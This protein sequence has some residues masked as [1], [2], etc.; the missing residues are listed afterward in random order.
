MR[1][2]S[3]ADRGRAFGFVVFTC[4]VLLFV[5]TDRAAADTIAVPA[6]FP[7]IQAAINAA[8]AGDC[9][10]VS[11]GDYFETI[12]FLGK[13]ITVVSTDGP[14][15]TV[16]NAGG[17]GSVVTFSQFE[18]NDSVLEGFRLTGGAGT[19]VD[20]MTF[21]G[22]GIVI[23]SASPTIRG[24]SIASNAASF[25]GG[26][27]SAFDSSPIIEGNAIQNNTA[28]QGAG[29]LMAEAGDPVITDNLVRNN[30]ASDAGGGLVFAGVN[31]S[32]S[33]NT[34]ETNVCLNG[35]GG[36][37]CVDGAFDISNNVF[38]GNNAA[39]G[40][41]IAFV[42]SSV[43]LFGN[44]FVDNE[45]TTRGGGCFASG[46]DVTCESNV[47]VG[48]SAATGGG[49]SIDLGFAVVIND[50]FTGNTATSFGGGIG[51]VNSGGV[52]AGCF[53]SQNVAGLGGGGIYV[54]GGDSEL[55]NVTSVDNEIT[56]ASARG[57]GLYLRSTSIL[58]RNS[59]IWGNTGGVQ[60]NV[61]TFGGGDPAF[62]T[63]VIEGGWTGAGFAVIDED[64][65]FADFAAGDYTLLPDSPCLNAGDSTA[66]GDLKIKS[67]YE[68]DSRFIC[69]LLD[70]GADEIDVPAGECPGVFI[71]GDCDVDG[72]VDIG[73]PLHAAFVLFTSA[74]VIECDD[75]CDS[76]DDGDIDVADVIYTLS[77]LF[78][79]GA[80]PPLS[81]FPSCGNDGT[82]DGIDC[83]SSAGCGG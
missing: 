3:F 76:N 9:V 56:I 6:D 82:D 80:A 58:T 23:L 51:S 47:Y 73:D 68:G 4:T 17:V 49:L 14:S 12:D 30:T 22:G 52:I 18:G 78:V 35:G 11:P 44:S 24:N 83:N 2:F 45:A 55:T 16:I 77:A 71:R 67:D 46:G 5:G 43:T 10:S 7:T 39:D 62:E 15:V 13:A 53:C 74:G 48:N 33:E 66:L 29:L 54:F 20:F 27:A 59:L 38:E 42:D 50:V 26:I 40:G 63:C 57:G 69:V 70:I 25:G 31:V 19:E 32:L 61:G 37:L 21:V 28:I 8:V 64:P 60:P 75:A 34:I 65:L 81:P 79:P 36:L 1:P 72:L 41:G